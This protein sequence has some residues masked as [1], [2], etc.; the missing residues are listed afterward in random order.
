MSIAHTQNLNFFLNYTT[1][2][3]RMRE[4]VTGA[5]VI[6]ALFDVS[7]IEWNRSTD[8]DSG[9]HLIQNIF[10]SPQKTDAVK[11]YIAR[12]INA[13]MI[14]VGAHLTTWTK[15]TIASEN[16]TNVA[17]ASRIAATEFKSNE[18]LFTLI[19]TRLM[20]YDDS[21]V[22][23]ALTPESGRRAEILVDYLSGHFDLSLAD[24]VSHE[25]Y[26]DQANVLGEML[27][28]AAFTPE[29]FSAHIYHASKFFENFDGVMMN[30]WDLF[31]QLNPIVE[32]NEEHRV[33]HNVSQGMVSDGLEM[34]QPIELEMRKTDIERVPHKEPTLLG[35]LADEAVL[36]LDF[37]DGLSVK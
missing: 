28:A 21:L 17:I 10:T 31:E 18:E 32:V 9:N 36:K 16:A 30:H 1:F 6:K 19:C 23:F 22:R 4:V 35:T 2:I 7:E 13:H 27:E 12:V 20:G 37:D 25:M 5:N 11:I 26:R 34:V 24:S 29:F 3:S 33:H 8:L 14:S 15:D